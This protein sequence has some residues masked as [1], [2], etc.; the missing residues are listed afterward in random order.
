MSN[1]LFCHFMPRHSWKTFKGE[2]TSIRTPLSCPKQSDVVL[3]LAGDEH[4]VTNLNSS[5]TVRGALNPKIWSIA[6]PWVS[7]F[8]QSCPVVTNKTKRKCVVPENVSIP[9][10]QNVNGNSKRE[11][12]VKA[13]VLKEKY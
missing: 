6:M 10:P 11:G 13:K 3:E 5:F 4:R 8:K 12:V 1:N 2:F 9:L 7:V